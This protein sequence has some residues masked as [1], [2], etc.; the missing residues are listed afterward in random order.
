MIIGLWNNPAYHAPA[1]SFESQ[2]TSLGAEQLQQV[3]R[4]SLRHG[5]LCVAQDRP[6]CTPSD[7]RDASDHRQA[8][9]PSSA[10]P[11]LLSWRHCAA[12]QMGV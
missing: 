1:K 7:A 2:T 8:P 11:A 12:L 6:V 3:L 10:V 9:I 4:H 5:A